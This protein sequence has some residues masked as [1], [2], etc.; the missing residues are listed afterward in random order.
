M[1][2]EATVAPAESANAINWQHS[3]V[4]YLRL[5]YIGCTAIALCLAVLFVPQLNDLASGPPQYL[6]AIADATAESLSK[7][8]S[9]L[10]PV[11][12][13]NDEDL[14]CHSFASSTQTL[15]VY[16]V[17]RF[18]GRTGDLCVSKYRRATAQ[19]P[20]SNTEVL[21]RDSG[22]NFGSLITDPERVIM[23]DANLI[24]F[25]SALL[26]SL[27]WR[28]IPNPSTAKMDDAMAQSLQG[29]SV[30]IKVVKARIADRHLLVA[31]VV[32]IIFVCSVTY[33][34]FVVQ[35]V[36]LHFNSVRQILSLW[37]QQLNWSMYF[38]SDL[39][40]VLVRAQSAFQK[41]QLYIRTQS[42]T[43]RIYRKSQHQVK[44]ALVRALDATD[45]QQLRS[46]IQH[47]LR[48]DDLD[49]MKAL[50]SKLEDTPSSM[51]ADVRLASLLE[52]LRDYCSAEEFETFRTEANSLLQQDGFRA[53]RNYVVSINNEL[54][55]RAQQA[56][57][58]EQSEEETSE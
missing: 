44:E 29:L 38:S 8:L 33:T 18:S 53:A 30:D 25:P 22:R 4:L 51:P 28:H 17:I 37:D 11:I 50:L 12:V 16:Y 5:V 24:H 52:N 35:R 47:C 1:S 46:T 57:E 43:E 55:V 54:R 19:D 23:T 10:Y 7:Q 39:N 2:P 31:Q 14:N 42:R 34:F 27:D 15:T 20:L 6:H 32:G 21:T 41:K 36:R 26:F 9:N 49:K 48:E 45:D 13:V 40:E 58:Q 3:K 56:A